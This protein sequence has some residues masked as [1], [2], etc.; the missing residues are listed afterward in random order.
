MAARFDLKS[1]F[2]ETSNN[3]LLQYFRSRDA[4]A[5]FKFHEPEE[6]RSEA[7]FEAWL[8]LPD[9][10]RA[11]LEVELRQIYFLDTEKGEKALILAADRQGEELEAAL[12]GQKNYYDRTIFACLRRPPYGTTRSNC[13]LLKTSVRFIGGSVEIFPK[14]QL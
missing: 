10:E 3:L 4:L 12:S 1:L 14:N 8:E 13:L 2:Q 6:V 7:I 5:E 11:E 9:S